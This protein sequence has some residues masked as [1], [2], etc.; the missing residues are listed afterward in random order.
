MPTTEIVQNKYREYKNYLKN[1]KWET[2]L[3]TSHLQCLAFEN[4]Y[5]LLFA[6]IKREVKINLFLVP[7][8]SFGT[9]N[10]KI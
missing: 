5:P 3:I 8:Q 9:R 4:N 10:R 2:L 7:K 6:R 1:I